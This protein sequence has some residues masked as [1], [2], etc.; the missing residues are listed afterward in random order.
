MGHGVIIAHTNLMA[1]KSLPGDPARGGNRMNHNLSIMGVEKT[2]FLC[3]D[4]GSLAPKTSQ[5]CFQ[6]DV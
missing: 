4:E 5:G 3:Q 1:I 6:L 2:L